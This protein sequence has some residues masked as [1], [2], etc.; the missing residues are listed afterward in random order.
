MDTH[1][2]TGITRFASYKEIAFA[3]FA[4]LDDDSRSNCTTKIAFAVV[5]AHLRR[6]CDGRE[7]H[8][9]ALGQR[10]YQNRSGNHPVDD[11]WAWCAGAK[12]ALAAHAPMPAVDCDGAKRKPLQARKGAATRLRVLEKKLLMRRMTEKRV[13][14]T[15]KQ[16][17]QLQKQHNLTRGRRDHCGADGLEL[18][19]DAEQSDEEEDLKSA[20]DSELDI[21]SSE[22]EVEGHDEE[23]PDDGEEVPEESHEEEI[24]QYPRES[25]RDGESSENDGIY[26][27][28]TSGFNPFFG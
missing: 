11:P 5:P 14:C 17:N 3:F 25:V 7:L 8:V 19:L 21:D 24:L 26:E 22:D 12:I 18:P 20:H 4:L 9:V 1:T 23:E 10:A 13:G 27:L 6:S 28:R 16:Q 15:C 2:H